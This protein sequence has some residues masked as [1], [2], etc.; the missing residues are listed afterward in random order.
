M[1]KISIFYKTF[2]KYQYKYCFTHTRDFFYII[3]SIINIG[4]NQSKADMEPDVAKTIK[5]ADL[6]TLHSFLGRF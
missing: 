3:I 1:L 5:I 2:H 4:K 6:T